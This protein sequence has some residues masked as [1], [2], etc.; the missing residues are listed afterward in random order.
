MGAEMPRIWP[1]AAM[2]GYGPTPAG[3]PHE[4]AREPNAG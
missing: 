1:A 3:Y 2:A 4:W